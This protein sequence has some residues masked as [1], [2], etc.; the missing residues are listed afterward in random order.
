MILP[1]RL[2]T[3]RVEWKLIASAISWTVEFNLIP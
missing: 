2:I 3:T 1:C